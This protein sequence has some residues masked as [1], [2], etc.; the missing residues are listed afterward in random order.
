MPIYTYRCDCGSNFDRLLPMNSTAPN[1]PTCGEPTRKIPAG[2]SLGGSAAAARPNTT[3]RSRSHP[4]ALWRDA[5]QGKPEKVRRELEFRERLAAKDV[6]GASSTLVGH[7]D[8][9]R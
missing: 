1:C 5:F 9:I 7:V 6:S 2:F 8:T 3:P 4:S